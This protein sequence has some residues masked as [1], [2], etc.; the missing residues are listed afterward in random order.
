MFRLV[1]PEATPDKDGNIV[2]IRFTSFGPL[3]YYEWGI[4]AD[5]QPYEC[6]KWCEDDFYEDSNYY[7]IITKEELLKEIDKHIEFLAK[8]GFSEE[9]SKY[10]DIKHWVESRV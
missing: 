3:E 10:N 7:R 1:R 2:I 4:N 9:A 6:Y 5:N 8:G